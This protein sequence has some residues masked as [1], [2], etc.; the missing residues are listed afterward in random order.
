MLSCL[1]GVKHV[2][3]PTILY[4]I[5]VCHLL[6]VDMPSMMICIQLYNYYSCG[7]AIILKVF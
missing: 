1:N 7:I 4:P 2:E 3:G 6:H 5:S